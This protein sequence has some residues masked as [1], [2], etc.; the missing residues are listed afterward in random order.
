MVTQRQ[1]LLLVQQL[2]T[3]IL[4]HIRQCCI[5]I[6][7]CTLPLLIIL[8]QWAHTH[9]HHTIILLLIIIHTRTHQVY[10]MLLLMKLLPRIKMEVRMSMILPLKKIKKK[11][12]LSMWA[13]KK[14]CQRRHQ[15][16]AIRHEVVHLHLHQP[17]LT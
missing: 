12:L 5:L 9:I 11:Q 15:H 2:S 14:L 17:I 16:P 10:E 6:I 1:Q 8:L 4:R 13:K 7:I 3:T